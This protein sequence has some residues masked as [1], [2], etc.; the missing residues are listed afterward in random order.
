MATFVGHTST[1]GEMA[2]NDQKQYSVATTKYTIDHNKYG[3][4]KYN[5]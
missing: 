3:F 5:Q 1:E 2:G 4:V